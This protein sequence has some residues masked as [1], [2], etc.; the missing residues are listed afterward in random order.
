MWR[1][2]LVVSFTEIHPLI[3]ET[4]HYM[5]WPLTERQQAKE[6]QTDRRTDR[7]VTEKHNIMPL[8]STVGCKNKETILTDNF[9]RH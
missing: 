4:S 3:K 5:K 2:Y 8:P 7:Q 9:L 1:L 6:E